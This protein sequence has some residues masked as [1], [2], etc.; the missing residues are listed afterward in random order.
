MANA[1]EEMIKRAVISGAAHALKCKG[2]NPN[3]SDSEVLREVMRDLRDI[4]R[5]IDGA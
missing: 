2:K 3:Q 5:E 1:N 4:I